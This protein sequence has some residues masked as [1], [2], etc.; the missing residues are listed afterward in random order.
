MKHLVFIGPPGAGKGT[1]AAFL[2]DSY[3]YNHVS[4]GDLLRHE[5]S[6]KS[7]IGQKVEGIMAAGEFVSDELIIAIL[8]KS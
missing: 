4:T 2:I 7:E 1:Q 6:S 8:K 3:G 5:I